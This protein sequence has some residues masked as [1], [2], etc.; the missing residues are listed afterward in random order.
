QN[1]PA[2]TDPKATQEWKARVESAIYNSETQL[3]ELSSEIKE[4][5]RRLDK[6]SITASATLAGPVSQPAPVPHTHPP[7]RYDGDPTSCRTFL[8]Q[9]EIQLSLHSSSFSCEKAKVAYVISLLKGRAAQWATAEWSR[10]S[11]ICS[12]YQSFS[13]E[14]SRVFDPVKPRQDAAHQLSRLRQGK[15]SVNDYA[16]RFRTLA[17][18][19]QWNNYALFDMFYQGL[20]EQVKDELAA[21]ELPQGV[22]NLIALAS[23]IDRRIQERREERA[24]RPV[25]HS[26]FQSRPSPSRTSP[27]VR[28]AV[29]EEPMQ[30][31]RTSLSREERERRLNEGLCF[32]CGSPDHQ[33]H[34]CP[35]K[36]KAP[37]ARRRRV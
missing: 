24:R 35:V 29:E 7:E 22:N 26:F 17:A 25:S 14:L 15:D 4:I 19:S 11:E 5:S 16:I 30:L 13:A 21:R 37:H 36:D 32:Y 10:G 2:L 8:T 23:R 20:S 34:G 18:D 3:G 28:H 27:L 9:C 6:A 1:V 12:S 31:G 33:I